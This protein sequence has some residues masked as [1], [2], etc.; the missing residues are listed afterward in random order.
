MGD[1]ISSLKADATP[2]TSSPDMPTT[3]Q[4]L[5]EEITE[6]EYKKLHPTPIE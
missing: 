5:Y 4:L 1:I 6:E 3:S 2:V